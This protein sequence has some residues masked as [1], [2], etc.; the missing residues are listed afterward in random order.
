VKAGDLQLLADLELHGQRVLLDRFG[1]G[2]GE[3]L[4]LGG[5][6]GAVT[7]LRKLSDDNCG[8]RRLGFTESHAFPP[9]QALE[10]TKV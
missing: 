5:L 9:E 10:L 6:E 2:L 1:D 8:N 4:G 7:G 3:A